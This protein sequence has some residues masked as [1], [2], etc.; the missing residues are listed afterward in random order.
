MDDSA[1]SQG[2]TLVF[3]ECLISR[4]LLTGIFLSLL[5]GYPVSGISSEEVCDHSTFATRV[6]QF[7][8]Q[9]EFAF[10]NIFYEKNLPLLEGSW[11]VKL[12]SSSVQGKCKMSHTDNL[13]FSSSHL[14]NKVRERK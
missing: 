11:L 6:Y 5:L 7:P 3:S 8:F 4:F 13:K 14:K 1:F 9:I 12:W 10:K 2:T